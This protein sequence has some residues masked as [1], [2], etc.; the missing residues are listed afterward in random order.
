VSNAPVN[1]DFDARLIHNAASRGSGEISTMRALKR[2]RIAVPLISIVAAFA[3]S[4]QAQEQQQHKPPPQGQAKPA[5]PAVRQGPPRAG[6]GQGQAFQG[7]AVRGPQGQQGQRFV[8]GNFPTRNFGGRPYHGHLAWEGGRWRHEMHNGRF[9]WWWDVGGVWYFYPQPMDG[10]PAY[11][12]DVEV[13]DDVAGGPDDDMDPGPGYPPPAAAYAPP[14]P[15]G[16]DPA[17][18]AVGGAI[19]GGVLGGLISGRPVGAAVGA[20][21]GGTIGAIAGAQAAARPGYYL[22]QGGC[23]YKYP[24]GQYAQVDPRNCY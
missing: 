3:F 15:P 2:S 24:S 11:V 7:Q 8:R 4:A 17:A 13:M 23:Y 6:Q 22:A 18:G 9:G 16:P 21:T 5:G 20:I 14:P 12:S 10:P 19:V 1:V